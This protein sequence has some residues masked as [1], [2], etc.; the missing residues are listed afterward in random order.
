MFTIL[1]ELNV[2]TYLDFGGADG[3]NAYAIATRCKLKKGNIFVSDIQS[4]FGNERVQMYNDLLTFRFL[5][6]FYLPFENNMFDFISMF[7]V[8]HH[9]KE[10]KL[11][12]NELYR[13][14]KPGGIFYVREHDC[15]DKETKL[16]ID[17]EHSLHEIT[18]KSD[19]DPSYLQKY[20]AKYF[21]KEE[22]YSLIEEVG[23]KPYIVNGKHLQTTPIGVT[24][25]YISVWIK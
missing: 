14:C 21:D 8:L 2:K 19:V 18:K 4:W 6:S 3:Q 22:L 17:I 12:L 1:E 15:I 13:I 9:I 10:Y 20:Y 7:Q 23:F 16:L 11:T 5:K 25:Y 24:R